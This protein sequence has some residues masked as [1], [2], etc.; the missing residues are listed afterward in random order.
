M[1][2]AQSCATRGGAAVWS[3]L[4]LEGEEALKTDPKPLPEVFPP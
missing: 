1:P 4:C 3:V 2:R